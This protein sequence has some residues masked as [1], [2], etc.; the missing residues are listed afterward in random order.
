MKTISLMFHI[1]R[2]VFLIADTCLW[3]KI[4][5]KLIPVIK[6]PT[7]KHQCKRKRSSAYE[8]KYCSAASNLSFLLHLQFTLSVLPTEWFLIW[9]FET[10]LIGRLITG[11]PRYCSSESAEWASSTKAGKVTEK[12][13]WDFNEFSSAEFAVYASHST[14]NA[15]IVRLLYAWELSFL[16]LR[17]KTDGSGHRAMC[18]LHTVSEAIERFM[19]QD[20]SSEIISGSSSEKWPTTSSLSSELTL[21][22]LLLLPHRLFRFSHPHW[23]LLHKLLLSR[24]REYLSNI[25]LLWQRTY[26]A[27]TQNVL[28]Y[29]PF[30]SQWPVEQM[31]LSW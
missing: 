24:H 18:V 30:S 11:Y 3:G 17:L 23:N 26:E 15:S 4:T 22:L 21:L 9:L 8:Q 28:A 16:A 27:Q 31:G 10:L 5:A 12:L 14:L 20:A 2:N 29:Q 1:N 7:F 6:S 13:T 25:P 19:E